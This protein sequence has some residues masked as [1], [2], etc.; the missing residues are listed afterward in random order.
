[1]ATGIAYIV[2]II[3]CVIAY[4]LTPCSEVEDFYI[5]A[6]IINHSVIYSL[7]TTN[8]IN[9]QKYDR[10]EYKTNNV[11][12][13]PKNITFHGIVILEYKTYPHCFYTCDMLI[14]TNQKNS[15]IVNDYFNKFFKIGGVIHM[16]CNDTKCSWGKF[17][18]NATRIKDEL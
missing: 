11:S 15:K 1:M 12:E 5:P 9:T 16:I 7:N 18:C 6:Y 3:N 4:P 13:L 17:I 8:T 14:I 10:L 2:L